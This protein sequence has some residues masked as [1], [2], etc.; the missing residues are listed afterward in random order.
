VK[1]LGPLLLCIF[2]AVGVILLGPILAQLA[3]SAF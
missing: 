2:P 3:K 1:M